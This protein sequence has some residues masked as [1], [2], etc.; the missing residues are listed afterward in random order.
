MAASTRHRPVIVASF[1]RGNLPEPPG[2][3]TGAIRPAASGAAAAA[4]EEQP[5]TTAAAAG[6]RFFSSTLSRSYIVSRAHK[7]PLASLASLLEPHLG[8][9]GREQQWSAYSRS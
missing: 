3:I 1:A 4:A 2:A 8:A 6:P 5:P 7:N 9:G